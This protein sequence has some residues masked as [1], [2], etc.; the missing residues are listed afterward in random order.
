[1][2]CLILVVGIKYRR[3]ANI[4]EVCGLFIAT[5]YLLNKSWEVECR[6]SSVESRV[7]GVECRESRV[8]VQD[9]V[10]KCRGDECRRSKSLNYEMSKFSDFD[11]RHSAPDTRLPTL[12]SRHSTPDT[13]LPTLDSRHST[14]D[15]R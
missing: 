8:G 1:M 9:S 15:T 4:C 13:R 7:S 10:F 12:D 3:S 6:E 11:L 5:F 14:P 2:L